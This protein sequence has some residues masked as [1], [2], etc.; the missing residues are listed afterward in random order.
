MSMDQSV[1]ANSDAD[2]KENCDVTVSGQNS[3]GVG[4]R[5]DILAR[6]FGV[7]SDRA[8]AARLKVAPATVANLRHGGRVPLRSTLL[9]IATAAGVRLDWLMTGEGPMREAEPRPGFREHEQAYRAKPLPPDVWDEA[10]LAWALGFV[11][12]QVGQEAP[13]AQRVELMLSA[14][15]EFR[16]MQGMPPL[17]EL[18]IDLLARS[19]EMA[20]TLLLAVRKPLADGARISRMLRIYAIAT[21]DDGEAP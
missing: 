13:A 1:N 4:A 3:D 9:A 15:A 2:A 7:S 6:E 16:R 11:E 20:E 21:G 19:L 8:L 17:P 10:N 12:K 18:D 5:L 14:A